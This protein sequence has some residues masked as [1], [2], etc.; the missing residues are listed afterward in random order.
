MS[1]LLCFLSLAASLSFTSKAHAQMPLYDEAGRT[2][3]ANTWQVDFQTTYYQATANYTKDG[4]EYVGLD[5]GHSFRLIDFDF[6]TR[7]VPTSRW[8]IYLSSRVSNAESND[9]INTR[10]N[11]TFT[12]AVIGTD[13][14]LYA[15][16]SFE[17]IPDLSVTVPVERV[18]AAA[19]EVL[20][21][22]GSLEATAKMIARMHWGR[23]DPFAFVGFNYR[24]ENRASLLPYGVGAELQLGSWMFGGEV[25]G[26]Q[27]VI[28]DSSN[29]N[30][31]QRIAIAARS[32]GALRYYSEN[33]SLL[34]TNFWLRK[35]FLD[36]WDFKLGAGTS[37]T[38]TNTAAGWN[39]IA[40]LSYFFE[41]WKSSPGSSSASSRPYRA[42][43]DNSG[44]FQ[45]EINDGVDQ[46]LFEAP[47]PPPLPPKPA[48]NP[49]K[50]KLQKE[51]DQTEFQ[52]QLKRPGRKKR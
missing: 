48:A 30:S 6:G 39:V 47:K 46:N 43:E 22:E 3:Q 31:L 18:D 11:S 24:D 40:G 34:E 52:I 25:R 2:Y 35:A 33:P 14:R 44:Q 19:D 49:E 42:V 23:L 37:I 4:G 17:L 20:N 38:G 8:G 45:E 32:G 10:R 21:R 26:Y 27:T 41:G 16:K 29:I 12:Q 1:V 51:L 13:Y 9:T 5:S 7:W 15:G 50:Q 36:S 28:K